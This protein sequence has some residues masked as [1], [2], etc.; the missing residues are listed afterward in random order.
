MAHEVKYVEASAC[1]QWVC[2]AVNKEQKK[3]KKNQV[4]GEKK[5]N[6]KSN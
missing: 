3:E 2:P 5:L 4:K 1:V 6:G